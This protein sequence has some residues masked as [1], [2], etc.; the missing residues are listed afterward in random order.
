MRFTPCCSDIGITNATTAG[1][2]SDNDLALSVGAIVGVVLGG[3]AVLLI[4]FSLLGVY[5]SFAS[6][7]AHVTAANAAIRVCAWQQSPRPSSAARV[8]HSS[9]GLEK[10]CVLLQ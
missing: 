2:G 10:V 4:I 6:T 5:Q 9:P 8:D 7:T 1:D 3:L